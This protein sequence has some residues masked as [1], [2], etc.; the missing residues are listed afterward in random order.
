[1]TKIWVSPFFYIKLLHTFIQNGNPCLSVY[2]MTPELAESTLGPN[3]ATEWHKDLLEQVGMDQRAEEEELA[4]QLMHPIL[5]LK[6][7][8][9]GGIWAIP[10]NRKGKTG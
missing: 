4:D 6:D 5:V 8:T 9:S 7:E 10:T 2:L 3:A 1:M